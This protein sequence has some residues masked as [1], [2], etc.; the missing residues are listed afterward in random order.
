MS[1]NHNETLNQI[2]NTVINNYLQSGDL[3]QLESNIQNEFRK[4]QIEVMEEA[5]SHKVSIKPVKKNAIV[6]EN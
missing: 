6:E 2:R 4:L 5:I 3:Y 1:D